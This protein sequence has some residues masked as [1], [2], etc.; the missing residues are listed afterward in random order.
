MQQA[1]QL[2]GVAYEDVGRV[3]AQLLER[4]V[5]DG[6]HPALA[7]AIAAG[8][9]GNADATASGPEEDFEYGLEFILDGIEA[10]AQRRTAP[11]S[12]DPQ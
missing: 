1:E 5:A 9:F 2:T 7:G 3:Y 4:V 12:S 11:P 8:A 10:L 6:G